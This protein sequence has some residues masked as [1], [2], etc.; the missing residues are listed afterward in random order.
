[1]IKLISSIDKYNLILVYI[2]LLVVKQSDIQADKP[3]YDKY[4]HEIVRCILATVNQS[5]TLDYLWI[6]YEAAAIAL[7]T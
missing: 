4:Y 7:C 5:E 3:Y 2:S 6:I 1:M